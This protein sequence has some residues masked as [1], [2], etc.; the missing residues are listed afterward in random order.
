[1]IPRANEAG[2]EVEP[3]EESRL[4]PIV[5]FGTSGLPAQEFPWLEEDVAEDVLVALMRLRDSGAL[6]RL[7]PAELPRVA[8]LMPE[9]RG[10]RDADRILRER[11]GM[12][13]GEFLARVLSS[14]GARQSGSE[15][16]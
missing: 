12:S 7:S 1:M 11:L 13:V 6:R 14:T 3:G 4:A 10:V 8:E 9:S 16:P 5:R 2:P 15:A